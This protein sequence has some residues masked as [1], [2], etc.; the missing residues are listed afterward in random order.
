MFIHDH[1]NSNLNIIL[2]LPYISYHHNNAVSNLPIFCENLKVHIYLQTVKSVLETS[3]GY[4]CTTSQYVDE[5]Y[6]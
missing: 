6:L 1:S 2:G 4:Q 5:K 3:K